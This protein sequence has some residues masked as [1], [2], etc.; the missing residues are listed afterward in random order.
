MIIQLTNADYIYGQRDWIDTVRTTAYPLKLSAVNSI[1]KNARETYISGI[2][3]DNDIP[4]RYLSFLNPEKKLKAIKAIAQ[5]AHQIGNHAFVYV[6]GLECITPDAA[7]RKH[8]LYKDH[9]DW[10]QRDIN[11]RPAKFSSKDAFWIR[12]GD[13]DVW[14]SPYALEWRKIYMKRIRQIAATGIDGI[15]VDIPYWMTHFTGW[16]KTW[17]SFDKYTVAAFKKETGLDAKK[18]IKI[19]DFNDAGFIKWVKFRMK[20]I[21]DFLTEINLNIKSV[22]PKCK[23]IPEIYPGLDESSVRVGADVYQIYRVADVITHE[24][25]DDAYYAAVRTPFEWYNFII[26]IKT[27]RAFAEGK[28][29]WILSYSWHDNKNVLPSEAMK[30]LFASETLSG[31]NVW[32]AKGFV[33]SSSNDIDARK[34]VYKWIKENKNLIY[35]PKKS[36]GMIG[37]YFSTNTRDMFPYEYIKNYRGMSALLI[38]NHFNYQIITP[39]T[40]NNFNGKI[41]IFDNVKCASDDELND[42]EKLKNKGIKFLVTKNTFAYDDNRVKRS[43]RVL[44]TMFKVSQPDTNIFESDEVL[45]FNKSP[46]AEYY[47]ILKSNMN[48]YFNH[49]DSAGIKIKKY[50]KEFGDKLYNFAGG[51]S[52]IKIQ[53]PLEIISSVS[54][55]NNHTYITLINV[56]ALCTVCGKDRDSASI[57]ILYKKSV[58]NNTVSVTP[59]LGKTYRVTA[60]ED[61]G[62]YYFSI[63]RLKRGAVVWIK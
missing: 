40:L 33:M 16:E 51:S 11:G 46:G 60:G 19:G 49:S 8:T 24:Y 61:N 17:A 38:N 56:K 32:D 45:Y 5:K 57:K 42:I 37:I 13:E 58:G 25:D 36:V 7:N 48:N 23:L 54:E 15:Y 35:A 21:T 12:K 52:S 20:T 50:Y 29:T 59:Y 53:A 28:P 31:A 43:R 3:V 4:G 27:F 9:P 34:E 6:A 10:V 41:L 14:V 55:E 44:Q 22:N 39:R 63:P 30:S 62:E 2:E 1:I 47:E 18:D 26:G